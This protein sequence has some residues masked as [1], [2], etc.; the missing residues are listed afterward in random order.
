MMQIQWKRGPQT[1]TTSKFEYKGEKT[2][3]LIDSFVKIS[4]FY[5]KGNDE[6]FAD[7]ITYEPKTCNI[8][9]DQ[10]NSNGETLMIAHQEVNMAVYVCKE[11]SKQTI[12]LENGNIEID[13]IWNIN[14]TT[15][16][17]KRLGSIMNVKNNTAKA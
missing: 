16:Q 2:Y 12:S 7:T 5:Y 3:K 15:V 10:I 11:D 8:Q 17:D 9:L 13:V 4:S 6:M 1:E 14:S